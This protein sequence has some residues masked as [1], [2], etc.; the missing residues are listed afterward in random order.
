MHST[1]YR[2]VARKDLHMG[3]ELRHGRDCVNMTA[4]CGP[5][6]QDSTSLDVESP[7]STSA[8]LEIV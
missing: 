2:I 3:S 4:L 5:V 7:L 6:E 8:P 1:L